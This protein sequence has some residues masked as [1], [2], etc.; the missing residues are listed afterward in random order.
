MPT[1][2]LGAGVSAVG[3]IVQGA[4]TAS[5]ESAA[6]A[7]AQQAAT[8]NKAVAQNVY[9]TNVANTGQDVSGGNAADSALEGLLGVGG[10]PAASQ[11]A[12]DNYLGSTNYNFVKNQGEQGIATANAPS[13]NSGATAK[14]LAT[15]DTGLAGNALS[16]YEGQLNNLTSAGNTAANTQANAGANYTS[17]VTSANNN[18]AKATESADIGTAGAENSAL[19]GLEGSALTASS[20]GGGALQG[21]S[22]T[23]QQ[24]QEQGAVS[25]GFGVSNPTLTQPALTF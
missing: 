1:A 7:A 16:G 10:N 22:T 14:A 25:S 5:A 12:F 4:N 15:Y 2:A 20:Y 24:I 19:Q 6:S 17:A 13:F 11:A 3:D 8:E 9:N 21:L 23:P 18:A